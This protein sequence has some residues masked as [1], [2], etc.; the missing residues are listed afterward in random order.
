MQ[1]APVPGA[2]LGIL[3][4]WKSVL[5]QGSLWGEWEDVAWVGQWAN[6]LQ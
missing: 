5:T 2:A 3:L 1:L 6:L 4:R